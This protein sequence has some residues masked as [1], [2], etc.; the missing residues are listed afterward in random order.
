MDDSCIFCKIIEG[1]IPCAKVYETDNVLAF[2]DIQP[3]HPGHAL[4]IPKKHYAN[5]FEL[6][7]E[8]GSELLDV[9]RRVGDAVVTATGA[10]GLNLVMNNNEAAGQLVFHAHW[11]IIPR[12]SDDGLAFWPQKAYESSEAMTRMAEA[13]TGAIK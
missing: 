2:L 6:P 9:A 1:V 7:S 4:I 12:F 8:L 3:I 13:I 11:H 10:D 5:L